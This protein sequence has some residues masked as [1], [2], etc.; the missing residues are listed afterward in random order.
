MSSHPKEHLPSYNDFGTYSL[1][2]VNSC[3]DLAK[4]TKSLLSVT[5]YT[6]N[7]DFL[8]RHRTL[9]VVPD[10]CSFSKINVLNLNV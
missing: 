10:T 3:N 6:Q 5:L 4:L 1:T 7:S 8:R 2:F 9:K